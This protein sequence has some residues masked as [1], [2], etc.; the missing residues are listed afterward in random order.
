MRAIETQGHCPCGLD[1]V[2][3]YDFLLHDKK[4]SI[5]RMYL[6]IPLKWLLF[7]DFFSQY[8]FSQENMIKSFQQ[9]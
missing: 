5:T 6:N 9:S 4:E 1:I 7:F 2:Q 8:R 3:V